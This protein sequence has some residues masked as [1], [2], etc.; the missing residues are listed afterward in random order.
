MA[1]PFSAY[2]SRHWAAALLACMLAVPCARAQDDP[3]LLERRVKAAFLYKF[4]GF[5]EWPQ[6][7]LRPDGPFA[8]AVVGDDALA[9]ELGQAVAGRSINGH[10]I[11]VRKLGEGENLGGAQMLFVAHDVK[12]APWA[13]S[14]ES[15]PVL[16]VTETGDALTRGGMIN[17]VAEDGHIR[18]EVAPDVAAKHGIRLSA[19]L[20][21]V[22]A[23]VQGAP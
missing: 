1:I 22:A 23:R 21:T 12:L 17:F 6:D 2:T 14:A 16:V 4:T 7:A 19:R 9:Q 20:L 5:V 8:I 18:F 13:R 10:P 3:A 11:T 15:Q